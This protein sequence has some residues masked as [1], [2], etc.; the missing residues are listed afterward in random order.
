V[1]LSIFKLF[2]FEDNKAIGVLEL[3]GAYSGRKEVV[4]E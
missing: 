3:T 2:G 4:N 1:Y